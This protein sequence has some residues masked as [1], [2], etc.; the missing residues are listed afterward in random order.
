M[1]D[2][3]DLWWR[4]GPGHSHRARKRNRRK[5]SPGRRAAT[6]LAALALLVAAGLGAYWVT[7]LALDRFGGSDF[8]AQDRSSTEVHV[9]IPPGADSHAMAK[10]LVDAGVIKRMLPFIEAYDSGGGEEIQSGTYRLYKR[11]PAAEALAALLDPEHNLVVVKVAIPDG[12]TMWDTY[13]ILAE[14]TGIPVA[15]FEAAA[16]EPEKLG[17]TADWFARK[18]GKEAVISV[19]GFLFPGTYDL[20]PGASA[21]E[22]LQTMVDRFFEVAAKVK[23]TSNAAA[24]GLS[25]HEVL[26][27]ASLV[28]VQAAT[29]AELPKAARIV[30]NRAVLKKVSCGCLEVSAT[31]RYWLRFQ[32]DAPAGEPTAQQLNDPQNP[33]NTGPASPGLPRGPISNPGQAAIEAALHP[34]K[35]NW[36]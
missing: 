35:G 17:L 9:R 15:D 20:D 16:S 7:G 33:W 25:P 30:Y 19:E 4:T 8:T 2:Q 24:L 22:I 12:S 36:T 3:L 28:Q 6:A 23:F 14:Q 31:A 18:D 34:A 29:E 10:V 32:G 26:T 5:R 27:V 11:M 13:A 21:Q 1:S